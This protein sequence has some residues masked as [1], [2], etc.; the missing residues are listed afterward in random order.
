MPSVSLTLG[1]AFPCLALPLGSTDLSLGLALGPPRGR[2]L[3]LLCLQLGLFLLA[4]ALGRKLG[5]S[6]KREFG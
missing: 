1:T 5:G 2:G 3:G 6:R 4:L